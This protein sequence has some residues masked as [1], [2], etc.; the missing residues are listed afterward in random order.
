MQFYRV[1]ISKFISLK[2]NIY[3][4]SPSKSTWYR[5]RSLYVTYA[6]IAILVVST[7]FLT[8]YDMLCKSAHGALREDNTRALGETG[9]V[10]EGEWKW[11]ELKCI[12]ARG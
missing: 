3:R 4:Y 9:I 8:S 6:G 7:R 12:W 1:S 11:E 10:N 5:S 2:S